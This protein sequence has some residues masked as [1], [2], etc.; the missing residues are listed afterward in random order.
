MKLEEEKTVLLP[1][2]SPLLLFVKEN[3]PTRNCELI[4]ER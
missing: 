3:V 2:P 1:P 4:A